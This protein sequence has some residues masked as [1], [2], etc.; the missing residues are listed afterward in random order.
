MA[1]KDKVENIDSVVEE[2]EPKEKDQKTKDQK[3]IKKSDKEFIKELEEKILM[4]KADEQNA[5]R[6][7]KSELASAKKYGAAGLARELIPVIDMLK[8]VVAAPT[9]SPEVQNYLLGFKMLIVQIEQALEAN[10]ITLIN[11]KVGDDFD[12]YLH[13][14]IET[15]DTDKVASGKIVE[16]V[17][18]GY[19]LHDRVIKHANV[20]VA[21]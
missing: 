12:M 16:V 3:E 14:A 21:K 5:V 13:Q 7:F 8:A 6:L 9:N 11:T 1:K 2:K 18:N 20:R 4:M 17:A 10:N 19:K 15:V